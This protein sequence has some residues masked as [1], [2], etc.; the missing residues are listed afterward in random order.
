MTTYLSIPVW[1]VSNPQQPD[2]TDYAFLRDMSILEPKSGPA[3]AYADTPLA[4]GRFALQWVLSGR[5]EID[6]VR[7][8]IATNLKGRYGRFWI[9]T[10]HRDLESSRVINISDTT[11]WVKASDYPSL[12]ALGN[13]RKHLGYFN[14]ITNA[15]TYLKVTAASNSGAEDSITSATAFSTVQVPLGV[16]HFSFLLLVRLASDDVMFK[17]WNPDTCEIT[18]EVVELT[19]EYP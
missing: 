8:F 15:W 7:S 3:I 1:D 10:F 17:W 16:G 9:P 19:A 13:Q 5:T 11:V 4:Q 2:G 18:L 14:H 12:F 6:A